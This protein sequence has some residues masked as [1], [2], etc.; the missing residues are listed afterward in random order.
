MAIGIPGMDVREL[1]RIPDNIRN[2]RV[3]GGVSPQGA[4]WQA[5][6][7]GNVASQAATNARA[8]AGL[9]GVAAAPVAPVAPAAPQNLAGRAM[10][11][12]GR[13]VNPDVG[14]LIKGT[15]KLTAK[16]APALGVVMGGAESA[17]DFSN[18]YADRFRRDTDLPDGVSGAFRTLTNIGNAAT[19]GLAERLGRGL[20]NMDGL[21]GAAARSAFMDGITQDNS[22]DQ[23][24]KE[25]GQ[26]SGPLG[27]GSRAVVPPGA[28]AGPAP[29]APATA[30]SP[31]PAAP[32]SLRDQVYAEN[33]TSNPNVVVRQGNSYSGG[34][35]GPNMQMYDRAGN[36]QLSL[37]EAAGGYVGTPTGPGAAPAPSVSDRVAS[38]EREA[39]LYRDIGR[40]NAEASLAQS[41]TPGGGQAF[42]L[43]T[44]NGMFRN[45]QASLRD[46]FRGDSPRTQ[47]FREQLAAEQQTRQAE[48]RQRAASED[49]ADARARYSADQSLRGT[50]YTVDSNARA[51]ATKAQS[52]DAIRQNTLDQGNYDAVRK[53]HMQYAKDT[54][55]GAMVEDTASTD[56]LIRAMDKVIPGY[57]TMS[58]AARAKHSGE[59]EVLMSLY[60]R[61]KGGDKNGVFE[62]LFGNDGPQ[63]DSLPDF[64]GGELR[65][66]GLAGALLGG[67][68]AQGYYWRQPNGQEL[69]LGKDL[70]E[71][72]I[73]LLT[74][75]GKKKKG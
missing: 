17:Q 63:R 14:G 69:Q 53:Q 57:T 11:A 29:G 26:S 43:G 70:T 10:G 13:F 55:T 59:A 16:S 62:A 4:A 5:Q 7:A 15:A 52:D 36:G 22:R 71:N 3:V 50:I 67:A 54:K 12:A 2:P 58:A 31:A 25:T 9:G 68:G 56:R 6:Q 21:S 39:Q 42:V 8:A 74:E 40:L 45:D 18:G 44:P 24:L 1:E 72:E 27:L 46:A 61:T 65:Q 47:R 34:N 41:G 23:Y 75:M 66:E 48:L 19:F 32:P 60:N 37:R 49:R 35:V 73:N 33:G 20:S 28:A 51:A 64:S 30:A 38:Y